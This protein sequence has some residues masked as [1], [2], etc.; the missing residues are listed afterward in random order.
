MSA[1]NY[2]ASNDDT[3]A[4]GKNGSGSHDT[5]PEDDLHRYV[6]DDQPRQ[7]RMIA[8]GQGAPARMVRGEAAPEGIMVSLLQR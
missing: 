1:P 5:A 7:K 3:I 4:P 2:Q 8:D 6:T